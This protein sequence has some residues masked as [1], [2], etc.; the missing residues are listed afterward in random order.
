M[1]RWLISSVPKPVLSVYIA[2]SNEL[3]SVYAILKAK[4]CI[5]IC[6][7]LQEPI[8]SSMRTPFCQSC[9]NTSGY[10]L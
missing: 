4:M 2:K 9:T 6:I 1:N 7:P 10:L 5:D 8:H 3:F